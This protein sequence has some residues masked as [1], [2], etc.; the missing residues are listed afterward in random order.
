MKRPII[1]KIDATLLDAIMFFVWLA[2]ISYVVIW[3]R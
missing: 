3:I 1:I 2:L